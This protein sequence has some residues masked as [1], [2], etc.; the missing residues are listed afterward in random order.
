MK[1]RQVGPWYLFDGKKKLRAGPTRDEG[2]LLQTKAVEEAGEKGKLPKGWKIF[3]VPPKTVVL[4]CGVGEV[5][6]PGVDAVEPD[7]ELLLP[8]PL[9]H[10]QDAE[11]RR[12]RCRR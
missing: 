1:R 6:C 2:E 9:R 8:D 7:Q 12:R 10:L 4:T 11:A 5:V 3:G